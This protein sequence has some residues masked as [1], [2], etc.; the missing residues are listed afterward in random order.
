ML[1]GNYANASTTAPQVQVRYGDLNLATAA[2]YARLRR[3]LR[4]A[5]EQVCGDDARGD[6]ALA[7]RQH[8]CVRD[9]VDKALAQVELQRRSTAAPA[10]G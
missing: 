9:A 4:S 10:S 7:V 6:I 1:V 5:G 2:G 3:R 8:Q